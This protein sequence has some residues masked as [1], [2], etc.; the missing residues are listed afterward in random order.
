MTLVRRFSLKVN[1]YAVMRHELRIVRLFLSNRESL[2]GKATKLIQM[3]FNQ[4]NNK[5]YKT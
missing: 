3:K 2:Q 4:E 1:S 5:I